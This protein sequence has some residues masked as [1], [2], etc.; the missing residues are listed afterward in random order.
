[1]TRALTVTTALLT[2]WVSYMA[3]QAIYHERDIADY[4][5]PTS[6]ATS[7]QMAS[8]AATVAL[9]EPAPMP[10]IVEEPTLAPLWAE[11]PLDAEVQHHIA[12][13]CTVYDIDASLVLAV[14]ETESMYK[15]DAIG[16]GGRAEGLFQIHERWHFDRMKKLGVDD[17]LDPV[18]NVSVGVDFLDEML[19]KGY[20]VE[21][22][23]MAYNGGEV[24][25]HKHRDAGEITKYVEDV[26]EAKEEIT[27]AIH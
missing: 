5:M 7:S 9:Q 25:A 6:V 8:T 24:Y 3:S 12:E 10:V 22:S 11:I 19:D 14:I 4:Q 15:T 21:W 17:L 13:L 23:L 18:Q 2:V 16:D 1:M 27:D 26:L 20:G